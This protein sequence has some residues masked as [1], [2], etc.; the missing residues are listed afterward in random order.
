ML[1]E[2]VYGTCYKETT[3]A[4]KKRSKFIFICCC[5][6]ILIFHRVTRL[7]HCHC[8]NS[9]VLHFLLC[10][11]GME[12]KQFFSLKQ[13][14]HLYIFHR[15][16]NTVHLFCLFAL[17]PMLAIANPSFALTIAWDFTF[18]WAAFICIISRERRYTYLFIWNLHRYA[19]DLQ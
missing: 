7:D 16:V 9:H 19:F 15:N 3:N 8:C 17:A 5:Y 10:Y 11:L 6:Q 2:A 14:Q 1:L 12:G 18:F 13:A 4:S